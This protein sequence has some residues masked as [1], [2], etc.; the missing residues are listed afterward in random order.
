M[1]R[2][3][4]IFPGAQCQCFSNFILYSNVPYKCAIIYKNA[5]RYKVLIVLCKKNICFKT[6]IITHLK[7]K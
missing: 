5:L 4:Y 2:G 6:L 3:F 7:C 1:G